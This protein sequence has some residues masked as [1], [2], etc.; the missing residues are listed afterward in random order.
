MIRILCLGIAVGTAAALTPSLAGG[1]HYVVLTVAWVVVAVLLVTYGTGRAVTAKYLVPGTLLLVVFTVAPV[2]A[3][4]QMSTTNYGDGTRTTKRETV[5]R[6]LANSVVQAPDS[7][8]FNLT[9]GTSGD[10]DFT[11]FLVDRATGTAYA[12]NRDGL[13]EV[14]PTV[15]RGFVTA[16]AGYTMLTP[17]QVN[18][19]AAQLKE[20]AVPVEGGAIRQRGL[21][22]AFEGRTMLRYDEAADTITDTATGTSYTVQRQG[23]REYFVDGQGERLSEQSWRAGVGLENY[24]RAFTDPR[25]LGGFL[26]IFGWTVVFA[27]GSVVLT[28]VVGLGLAVMLNDSR[29]RGQ[30]VYRSILLLPYAIPGFISILVWSGFFNQEFG[31]INNLTGLDIDW[32]GDPWG[33]KAALLLLNLWLGFPYMFLVATGALQ[34]IPAE[35]RE[36]ATID[37]AGAFTAFRRITLPLLLVAVAPILVASFAFNFNNYNVIELLTHGGPFT[38]DHPD[39]GATDILISYTVRLAFGAGGAQFGFAAAIATLLFVITGVLA[40]AQFRAT[41]SLEEV[42]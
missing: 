26:R 32:L 41:R 14:S 36:A 31:L 38:P 35:L 1:G 16:A 8:T 3:T 24:R 21:R 19:A 2:L 29:V 33:A 9:V 17:K 5:E 4:V 13:K 11:F 6:I 27:A 34:S 37:G 22:E 39:A 28:F 18:D 40:A 23:D 15:T 20:F 25:I 42:H 10:S 7:P 30:K 12:G